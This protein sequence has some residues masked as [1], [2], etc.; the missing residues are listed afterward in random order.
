M[1]YQVEITLDIPRERVIELFDSFD[2]LKKWQPGLEKV[3]H[4]SG[5]PGQ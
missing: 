3:E 5:E 1:K 2:N 4:T